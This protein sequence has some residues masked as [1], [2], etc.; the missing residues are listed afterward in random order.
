M[1]CSQ[2]NY[3]KNTLATLLYIKIYKSNN[4]FHICTFFAHPIKQ[5]NIPH[6]VILVDGPHVQMFKI[7][8]IIVMAWETMK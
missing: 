4:G 1:W 7:V 2:Y 5:V 8:Y 6:Y 3:G